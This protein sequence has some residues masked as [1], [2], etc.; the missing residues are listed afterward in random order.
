MHWF[1]HHAEDLSRKSRSFLTLALGYFFGKFT[2]KGIGPG[3]RHGNPA[4][5]RARRA[6]RNHDLAAAEG[7]GPFLLFLFAVGYAVGP[8][9]VRGRG[10]GWSA[11]RRCLRQSSAS[12]ACWRRSS[13]PRSAH[14]DLGYAAGLYF[15]VRRPSP[16]QWGLSTD[17]VN[18]AG[19][20]PEAAKQTLDSMPI[21]YC[22]ELHVRH[23]PARALVIAPCWA[24]CCCASTSPAGVQG[25]RGEAWRHQGAG[26]WRAPGGTA[27][28]CA[29]FR[30]KSGGKGRRSQGGRG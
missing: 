2:Y 1:R 11:A 27:G 26:R 5:R 14:Y 8:Q 18:R 4:G 19:L 16:P 25:I 12:F 23:G 28:S 22:R 13:L 30:V 15:P 29:R 9:F 6:A 21:A 7:N 10:E 24:P 3:L 17:A 20:T